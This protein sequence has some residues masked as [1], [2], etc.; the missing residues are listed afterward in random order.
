MIAR[1]LALLGLTQPQ[2]ARH[3]GLV[4]IIEAAA[5]PTDVPTRCAW[6]ATD[7]DPAIWGLD[8]W[9]C[10]PCAL[11]DPLRAVTASLCPTVLPRR[12]MHVCIGDYRLG[13]IQASGEL[14][15]AGDGHL[16]GPAELLT[17]T[18]SGTDAI[19]A[20]VERARR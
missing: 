2:P 1:L 13:A 10:V 18:A 16:D 19:R 8:G 15:F 12:V 9:T 11:A 3:A 4:G 20:L 7:A 6:C 5:S 17:T 14:W